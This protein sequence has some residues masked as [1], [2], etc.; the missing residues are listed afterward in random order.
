[1]KLSKSGLDFI[2]GFEGCCLT[3]CKAVKTEKY[4]TIGYGHYGADVYPGMK[5][6]KAQA[7]TLLA[8]DM[9]RYEAAVNN[10]KMSLNQNEFDALVSFCYNCGAGNLKRLVSGR[11]KTQIADAMLLYNKSGGNVLR[12][13]TRRREAERKMFL[14][15]VGVST[16]ATKSVDDVARDVL[17]GVYGNGEDRKKKL[18]SAGYNYKEVQSAVNRLLK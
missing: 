13:L 8:N 5:I 17:K 1:M 16:K 12:G 11:S 10:L 9:G 18:E 14:S 7:E 3:A 6:T 2:K 15:K 4:L